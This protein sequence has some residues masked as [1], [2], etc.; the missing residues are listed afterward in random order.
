LAVEEDSVTDELDDLTTGDEFPCSPLEYISAE[1][2]LFPSVSV[3]LFPL[4]PPHAAKIS[5]NATMPN[6]TIRCFRFIYFLH[7]ALNHRLS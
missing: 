6:K 1:D 4:S 5:A 3:L 2:E 7:L